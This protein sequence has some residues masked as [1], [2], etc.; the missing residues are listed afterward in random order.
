MWR[1]SVEKV[2]HFGSLHRA[3]LSFL[4][5]MPLP[6]QV[7]SSE[8]ASQTPLSVTD[9]VFITAPKSQKQQH[10]LE[11]LL[12][13]H[14]DFVALV[15]LFVYRGFLSFQKEIPWVSNNLSD[16]KVRLSPDKGGPA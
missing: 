11:Q 16:L 6:S 5:T 10:S 9:V 15:V 12:S 13:S 2:R 4:A 14:S 1:L 3:G 7:H 8:C